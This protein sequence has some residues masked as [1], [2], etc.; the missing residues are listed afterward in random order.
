[1]KKINKINIRGQFNKNNIELYL[2]TKNYLVQLVGVKNSIFSLYLRSPQVSKVWNGYINQ[3]SIKGYGYSLINVRTFVNLSQ[4]KINIH[5]APQRLNTKD[6][7]WFVGFTDGEGCF[8]IYKEKKY[9]NNWRHEYSIGVQL[10]DIRLLYKIKNLLNCGKI[11]KYNNVAIFVIK[12]ITHLLKIILPIFDYFPLLTENK[13]VRYINFRNT[14]LKK[15]INSKRA[16]N[17]EILLAKELLNNPNFNRYYNILIEDLFPILNSNK[18][19]SFPDLP[20]EGCFAKVEGF[21]WKPSYPALIKDQSQEDQREVN[22][23]DNWIVGFTE[24]EGSFYFIKK[25]Q[26]SDVTSDVTSI[27]W[28][29]YARSGGSTSQREVDLPSSFSFLRAEYRLSQNDNLFLLSKIIEKLKLKRAPSLQ[30]NSKNHYYIIA[31]SKITIQNVINFFI[32]T[33]LVKFKGIKCLQFQLWLKGI[34]N[35]ARY[36]NIIIPQKHKYN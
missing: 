16:T 14:L 2:L 3:Q 21:L 11:R 24:A 35:I 26:T 20:K 10:E 8:T 7:Q 32:N 31:T 5:K 6:I 36:K 25:K 22:Y 23:F 9:L 1:M 33:S 29:G 17:E 12:K 13:R 28:P 30:S 4:S 15:V 34:K 27:P 19:F 18:F